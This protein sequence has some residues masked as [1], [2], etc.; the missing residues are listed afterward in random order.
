MADE[1]KP[2]SPESEKEISRRAFFTRVGLGSLGIAA[3]GTLTFAYRYLSPNVLY[4]PSPIVNA[5]RPDSYPPNSVTLDPKM[6]I[7]IIHLQQG[8]FSLSAICTHLGCMTAW[9]QSLGII[10]CPC[11]GS[12]F[13]DEGVVLHGPAPK[14]L[15]WFK[16]WLNADGELLVDRST[17]IAPFHFLRI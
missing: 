15:P 6:A 8:F 13:T 12:K 4:E 14:P 10:A 3:A 16:L 1:E 2:D 9:K 7:Y 5:G 17:I 11:H